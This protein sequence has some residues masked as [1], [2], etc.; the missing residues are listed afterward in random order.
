MNSRMSEIKKLIEDEIAELKN[1]YEKDKPKVELMRFPFDHEEINEALESLLT[2]NVTMGQKVMKFET[3]W[4]DYIGK[5]QSVMVNSG[6]SANLLAL[7]VLS[8]KKL[9]NRIKK[10]DEIIT[11]A[12]TWSTT[13]FPI[14]N[15]G[16]K[17]HI[18]D[19]D[20]EN[21]IVDTNTIN[22][23]IN[24]KTS[25]IM[26]VHLLGNPV[27]M[28]SIMDLAEDHNLWVIEDS[29]EAHGAKIG[30]EYAG[31]FG[32]LSTF[33]FFFS[34]HI[35]TIEGGIVMGD[36]PYLMDLAKSYRAHGWVR[37]RS[38][39]QAIAKLYPEIDPRFMFVTQG[40]NLRPTEIQGSFGIQQIKK[41]EDFILK[42][43]KAVNY[44]IKNI[45]NFDDLF[46]VPTQRPNT[47]HAYF[48]FPLI[49]KIDSGINRTALVEYLESH[50]IST[51]PIMGGNIIRHP[52]LEKDEF[53]SS[54]K[55]HNADY[56]M[57]NGLF[58]G[59]HQD[60]RDIDLEH[61]V[62]IIN[63]FIALPN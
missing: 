43:H 47:R 48:G 44:W 45:N 40:Y 14:I 2:T 26:P 8:S 39:K 7:S 25:A 50:N 29:C 35:T 17:P 32:H 56:I 11:P 33:S 16:A 54:G 20:L 12:L 41:L 63:Q 52:A 27:D 57:N 59:N 28:P 51:R 24:P 4:S 34:H 49:P 60:L 6:S 1:S 36:D 61:F 3:L 30:N 31:S 62:I 13:V 5:N 9:E 55:L 58:I 22:E 15:I 19:V 37:E 18:V 23:A 21:L 38:D 53:V 42:R 46:I 10:G